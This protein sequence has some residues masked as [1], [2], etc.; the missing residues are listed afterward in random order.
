MSPIDGQPDR[1]SSASALEAARAA[2]RAAGDIM[3]S[4]ISEVLEILRSRLISDS[5][6]EF[7]AS[8][9]PLPKNH[10]RETEKTIRYRICCDGESSKVTINRCSIY[11][12]DHTSLMIIDTMVDE[13]IKVMHNAGI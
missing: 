3:D 6:L 12:H 7:I 11:L 5:S 8:E 1:R 9:G 2:A 13:A 10:R 4:E